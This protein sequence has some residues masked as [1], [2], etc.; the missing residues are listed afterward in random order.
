MTQ[1]LR[2]VRQR[3]WAT[4][5]DIEWIAPEETQADALLDLQ[6][7]NN[8]L[9]VFRVDSDN[10]IQR[11]VVALAASR[12]H[13]ANIDYAIFDDDELIVQGIDITQTVGE[14]PDKTANM[15]HHDIHN[16]T[17]R[18]I[19][20][21]ARTIALADH[22]RIHRRDIQTML[23]DALQSGD[24]EPDVVRPGVLTRIR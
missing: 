2:L 10:D 1:Y 4:F 13:V 3:R 21:L 8:R 5:P 16:L 7:R 6:T 15:L 19:E 22:T 14:T 17:V 18:Q 11:V 23:R 12:D 24:L 20:L 9:S